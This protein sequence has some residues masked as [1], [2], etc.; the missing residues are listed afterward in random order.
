MQRLSKVFNDSLMTGSQR[1][2]E[3][4]RAKYGLYEFCQSVC[5][6]FLTHWRQGINSRDA[7]E[8]QSIQTTIAR[9]MQTSFAR[10]WK[11]SQNNHLDEL[12]H[13][14]SAEVNRMSRKCT[15][16]EALKADFAEVMADRKDR[17]QEVI[18]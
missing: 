3:I 16:Y 12:R 5:T 9:N 8:L 4:D 6:K 2:I 13:A 11:F 15:E 7:A 17:E 14:A 18:R 10:V 1:H